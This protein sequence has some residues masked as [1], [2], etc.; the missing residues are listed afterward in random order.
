MRSGAIGSIIG[1]VPG[2]GEGTI[3]GRA[4]SANDFKPSGVLLPMRAV[5]I[6]GS[7]MMAILLGPLPAEPLRVCRHAGVLVAVICAIL[8]LSVAQLWPRPWFGMWGTASA[9][10]AGGRGRYAGGP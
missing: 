1:A 8:D 5:G 6:S 10:Q 9:L 4:D 3:R 2:I 7:A